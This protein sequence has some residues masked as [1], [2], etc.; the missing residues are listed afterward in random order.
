MKKWNVE[1]IALYLSLFASICTISGVSIWGIIKFMNGENEKSKYTENVLLDESTIEDGTAEVLENVP[2]EVMES[3][4][5]IQEGGNIGVEEQSLEEND[6]K[7]DEIDWAW[8]YEGSVDDMRLYLKNTPSELG[9]DV[10]KYQETIDWE[11]VKADGI[12]FAII[13]IGSRG[14]KYG[15]IS[16]D[17]KFNENMIGATANGIKT[18]VYFYSQAI[19]QEEME[20]EICEILK[21]IEGYSLDY[22]IGIELVCEGNDYRTYTLSTKEYQKEYIDLIKYFCTRIEQNGHIPMIYGPMEWFQQFPTGTF[23]EYYK[24]VYSS[25]LAPNNIENCVVWQYKRDT[26]GIIDGITHVSIDL[27]VYNVKND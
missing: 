5:N 14:Y 19:N 20:E 22:P 26:R 3:D 23:D 15:N 4:K 2:K 24:W 21:A 1:K 13:R 7:S 12:D 10:S 18:G 27:S 9:I 6:K 8:E 25:E 11:R 17:S 16:L